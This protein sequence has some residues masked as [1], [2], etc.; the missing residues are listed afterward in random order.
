M[1]HILLGI[2]GGGTKTEALAVSV[3]N[4]DS[5]RCRS[6]GS[7]YQSTGIAPA[8]AV[9]QELRRRCLDQ[10][11]AVPEEIAAGGFGIAG[12]DR[13]KDEAVLHP[14]FAALVAP[15]PF[16][17][18]N[19]AD[20]ALRA[21]TDDGI[22]IGVVSGTGCN[23]MGLNRAGRRFRVGG[24]GPEFG[25]LGSASDIGTAGLQAAF[26]SLDDRGPATLLSKLIISRLSLDRLDDIVDFF[27]AD[28]T[29]GG[30]EPGLNL[31]LLAP[32]VFDAAEQG[33][34]ESIRILC[35]AGTELG[36]SARAVARNLF[37]ANEEFVMVMG[38]S[39]L[40]RGRTHHVVDALTEDVRSEL[41]GVVPRVLS[42]TPATG[43]LL[44]AADIFATSM[45]S[46]DRAEFY[47]RLNQTLQ[48][49]EG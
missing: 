31:G 22:G 15:A 34:K 20:L 30:E 18:L 44:H 49:D 13:P 27:L 25:D 12:L 16:V 9:W 10:F 7:N 17:L 5:C 37:S 4:W 48:T 35:W 39:V 23:A 45:N 26:R 43:A 46:G 42:A 1:P 8:E 40:Q 24:I 19:D 6:T 29:A 28:N 38:G 32:L 14:V 2:D 47:H 3:R 11:H 41:P 21:G 36:V 33:D